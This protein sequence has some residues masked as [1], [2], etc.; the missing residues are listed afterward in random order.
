MAQMSA[1]ARRRLDERLGPVA[2]A[3][4]PRPR[5]GWLRAVRDALGMSTTDVGHRM[6]VT[7]SRVTQIEQAEVAGNIKLETLER[8]ADAL[9]CKVVY[10]IVPKSGSLDGAV[11]A[12]ALHTATEQHA[13]AAHTMRLEDQ[14][15]EIDAEAIE[16]LADRLIDRRGLWA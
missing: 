8:A 5:A 11:R 14:A 6:G 1:L 9:G 2:D 16:A 12:Q 7:R 3:V 4:G 15:S 10:A 13:R